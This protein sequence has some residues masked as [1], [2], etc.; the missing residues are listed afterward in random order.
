MPKANLKRKGSL[1]EVKTTPKSPRGEDRFGDLR[2]S[3]SDVSKVDGH[4]AGKGPWVVNAEDAEVRRKRAEREARKEPATPERI[5]VIF[6]QSMP[7]LPAIE[8]DEEVNRLLRQ[9]ED[10][11]GVMSE[12]DGN[13]LGSEDSGDETGG[14][15]TVGGNL[16]RSVPNR[17]ENGGGN[18][19]NQGGHSG[20]AQDVPPPG[21]A[22]GPERQGGGG[23][24]GA[25][26]AGGADEREGD[27]QGGQG[28][29]QAA[30]AP[31]T[32]LVYESRDTKVPVFFEALAPFQEA[33]NRALEPIVLSGRYGEE[34]VGYDSLVFN[35]KLRCF[36]LICLND[37][38][39]ALLVT[40]VSNVSIGTKKYRAWSMGEEPDIF[41]MVMF[42]GK[43]TSTS[44][45]NVAGILA[46]YN[47]GI[48]LQGCRFDR[49]V[50]QEN[51]RR[52]DIKADQSFYNFVR[53]K[54]WELRFIGGKADCFVGNH[55][56]PGAGNQVSQ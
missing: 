44:L 43:S 2:R 49:I 41:S 25:N 53:T 7:Q 47:R 17:Q 39:K 35:R 29:L 11:V 22:G 15:Q 9:E 52:V 24:A 46:H 50:E 3:K 20:S 19:R 26:N 32:L 31:L 6:T 23:G 8:E 33:L 28:Y 42:L 5:S 54:G 40:L 56:G 10:E 55:T 48:P 37:T 21:G 1:P 51:S 13:L 14:W 16:P 36:R 30:R 34:M 18:S 12:S 38:S 4:K 27:A 45:E